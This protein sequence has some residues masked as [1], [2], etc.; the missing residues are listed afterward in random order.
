MVS[1]PCHFAYS[2]FSPRRLLWA[3]LW[4][5]R[6]LLLFSSNLYQC[7][8]SR[9]WTTVDLPNKTVKVRLLQ[10]NYTSC[11]SYTNQTSPLSELPI[12]SRSYKLCYCAFLQ[13]FSFCTMRVSTKRHKSV[14]R[15]QL[16][17]RLNSVSC[18]Y[19]LQL[20][21]KPCT[22]ILVPS[23]VARWKELA[24]EYSGLLSS[25]AGLSYPGFVR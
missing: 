9:S 3:S 18:G 10:P 5:P 14:Y 25:V 15:Q 23:P 2:A 12:A 17:S 8:L 6:V 19:W 20:F 1:I 13:L 21:G 22:Q 11:W 4:A 24:T 7:I 16:G